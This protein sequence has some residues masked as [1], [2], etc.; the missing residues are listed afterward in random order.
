MR[1]RAGRAG[2]PVDDLQGK[3]H[4]TRACSTKRLADHGR[5]SPSLLEDIRGEQAPAVRFDPKHAGVADIGNPNKPKRTSDH[6]SM[7]ETS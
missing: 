3:A 5:R 7:E 4:D 6:T 2:R 1:I